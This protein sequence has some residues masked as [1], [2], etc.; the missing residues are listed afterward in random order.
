[1]G[2]KP[3]QVGPL[4]VEVRVVEIVVVESVIAITVGKSLDDQEVESPRVRK[5]RD[6]SQN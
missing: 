2:V 3:V 1:M 6:R 4:K 5:G